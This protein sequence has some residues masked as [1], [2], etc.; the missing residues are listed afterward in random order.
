[1]CERWSRRRDALSC[2]SSRDHLSDRWLH[3]QCPLCVCVCVSWWT[4]AQFSHP[5]RWLINLR[6]L[7]EIPATTQFY[8]TALKWPGA[9]VVCCPCGIPAPQRFGPRPS[10][11]PPLPLLTWVACLSSW[12]SQ[13][14][15]ISMWIS[16]DNLPHLWLPSSW[17]EMTVI[18]TNVSVLYD[19]IL[20]ASLSS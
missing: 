11:P 19:R 7:K 12:V 16:V 17:L 18:F 8:A 20:A 13:Q 6:S 9:R 1:M 15:A 14:P 4:H 3:C 2:R 10:A 5:S